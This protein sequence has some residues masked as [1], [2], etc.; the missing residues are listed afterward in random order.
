MAPTTFEISLEPRYRDVDPNGHVNHAVY[1]TYMEEARAAYWR[2]VVGGPLSEAGVAIVSLEIDYLAELSLEDTVTVGMWI[3]ELGESSIPQ[4]YELQANGEI[5]AT[6][7]AVMVAFD[8]DSRASRPLPDSW[9]A[10]IEDHE[11]AHN[12]P[13]A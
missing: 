10:A 12:N 9:R 13:I 2:T 7:T 8:R 6:G 4:H 5:V 11:E 3:G 1:A